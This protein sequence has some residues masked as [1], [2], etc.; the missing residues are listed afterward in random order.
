MAAPMMA[1]AYNNHRQDEFQ[2]VLRRAILWST[3][4][5]VPLAA[6]M[7]LVPQFLLG[8]FGP[9]FRAGAPILRILAIGQLVNGLTGPCGFSLL[10][11]GRQRD[12]A[13]ITA[14]VA[15]LTLIG[16]YLII[17]I[18]GGVGAATVTAGSVAALNGS[19]LAWTL[20][21][22]TGRPHPTAQA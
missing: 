17:P 4:G 19:M 3:L 9:G 21:R 7:L 18:W 11:T 5:V 12:F 2:V 1:A 20:L 22:V 10:M 14:V 13:I 15:G 8:L 16:G 6:V